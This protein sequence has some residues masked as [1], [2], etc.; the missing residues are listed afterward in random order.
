MTFIKQLGVDLPKSDWDTSQFGLGYLLQ[1]VLQDIEIAL[2]D[3]ASS[4]GKNEIEG[5]LSDGAGRT[6]GSRP[7]GGRFWRWKYRY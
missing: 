3:A 1:K 6:S 5:R 4:K 2:T 7:L